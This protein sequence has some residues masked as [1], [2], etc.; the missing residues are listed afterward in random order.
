M[1]GPH[2]WKINVSKWYQ[3][4]CQNMPGCKRGSLGSVLVRDEYV[5][6]ADC[7]HA[8]EF[9][10]HMVTKSNLLSNWIICEHGAQKLDARSKLLWSYIYMYRCF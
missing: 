4:S 7:L 1:F 2:A 8:H 9:W 6:G 10:H 3:I 5:F